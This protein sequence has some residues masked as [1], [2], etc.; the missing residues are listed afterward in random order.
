MKIREVKRSVF[1]IV[2]CILF[3]WGE[4]F[5]QGEA[6]LLFLY[7]PTS[8][9]IYGM[10][11]ASVAVSSDDPLA[12]SRNPAM[13]GIQALY[14]NFSAGYN[15]VDWFPT[16]HLDLYFK[17]YA[18]NGGF[19]FN[20]LTAGSL[21][22]AV[23]FGYSRVH[24]DYGELVY[25][26]PNSPEPLGTVHA[27]DEADLFSLGVALDH[28]VKIAAGVTF[29]K[30]TSKPGAYVANNTL[31]T[32][33]AK[34]NLFDWGIF[35]E[36]P[37]HLLL[38]MN[39]ADRLEIVPGLSPF[40]HLTFGFT[41][42]N[43]GKESIHYGDPH[44]GDPLPR[45]ARVGIG[46][47][48]GLTYLKQEH[49]FEPLSFKWTIEANDL[50]L[51]RK[52]NGTW[53]YQ[54]GLGDIDFFND[55]IIGKANKLN[56]RLKGYKLTFFEC[57]SLYGGHF[58]EDRNHG[59]RNFSTDGTSIS[60]LGFMKLM[61]MLFEVPD[62]DSVWG[63]LRRLDVRYNQSSITAHDSPLIGTKFTSWSITFSQSP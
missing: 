22:L 44:Q 59:N 17:T 36:M 23:G 41:N 55:L 13:L 54:T 2:F 52:N 62:D 56:E 61:S 58:D 8:T 53:Q 19:N 30:L 27:Y 40:T 38:T 37:V 24:F 51:N 28:P 45:V 3:A 60:S 7:L 32:F 14:K 31:R 48:A 15:Y 50:L 63:I 21:P 35:A 39:K 12:G 9:E 33:E 26:S 1:R 42:C 29:K 34:V 18:V 4:S 20:T 25:T 49:R 57:V 16:Y 5:S 43:L 47:N 46:F 6:A 11:W 10:G